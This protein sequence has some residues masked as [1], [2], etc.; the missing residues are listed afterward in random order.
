MNKLV[1]CWGK[2]GSSIRNHPRQSDASDVL[3]FSSILKHLHDFPVGT[4]RIFHTTPR[5]MVVASF[6]SGCCRCLCCWCGFCCCCCCC[7]CCCCSSFHHLMLQ[8][9]T[10]SQHLSGAPHFTT[11][12][13]L[14]ASHSTTHSYLSVCCCW[15]SWASLSLLLKRTFRCAVF[16]Y[17][18]KSKAEVRQRQ[19]ERETKDIKQ[20]HIKGSF[21]CRF[22]W[23]GFWPFL[24]G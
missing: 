3:T 8:L 17:M 13:W 15:L 11:R 23:L 19:R 20:N 1:S 9:F 22:V 10:I 21:G 14:H 5:T 12:R 18:A 7:G 24:A 16:V 2:R 6:F 4:W